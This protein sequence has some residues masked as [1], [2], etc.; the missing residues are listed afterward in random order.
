MYGCPEN[1]V[2]TL[3]QRCIL[4]KIPTLN[5]ETTFRQC[6]VNIVATLLPTLGTFRHCCVNVV[7][8]MVP[9]VVLGQFRST[10]T[11]TFKFEFS[12]HLQHQHWHNYILSETHSSTVFESM[13]FI[14]KTIKSC[15]LKSL[16][17]P[18]NYIITLQVKMNWF[19]YSEFY[20]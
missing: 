13:F 14:S 3:Y 17:W 12:T 16:F 5:V 8:M 7:S 1:I 9:N 6:C 2:W 20:S 11:V 4:T 10:M 19:N 15:F 18:W